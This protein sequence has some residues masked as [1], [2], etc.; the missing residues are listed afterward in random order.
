MSTKH[1]PH[2][3]PSLVLD[4]VPV[5]DPSDGLLSCRVC[6]NTLSA[7]EAGR[8]E[9]RVAEHREEAQSLSAR[10]EVT[11]ELLRR[12]KPEAARAKALQRE[13][14]AARARVEDLSACL[15]AAIAMNAEL[16][17]GFENQS[18]DF[19]MFI[20]DVRLHVGSVES[21][22]LEAL[23]AARQTTFPKRQ[24]PHPQHSPKL[25]DELRNE[26]ND[27]R[28]ECRRSTLH[29]SNEI[30][31]HDR[32]AQELRERS[33]S[34]QQE[35]QQELHQE[36]SH[37]H[38]IRRQSTI[39]GAT[40]RQ[41]EEE[42][43][44]LREQLSL[45]DH[46]LSE[47]K[48]EAT[49]FKNLSGTEIEQYRQE[50]ALCKQRHSEWREAQDVI[51]KSSLL[52]RQRREQRKQ[53]CTEQKKVLWEAIE[54]AYKGSRMRIAHLAAADKHVNRNKAHGKKTLQWKDKDVK[55]SKDSKGIRF[56]EW[57]SIRNPSKI[58]KF[59]LNEVTRIM[60]ARDIPPELLPE[61]RSW[62]C[63]KLWICGVP[64]IFWTHLDSVAQS[65][66]IALSHLCVNL[67]SLHSH[68]LAVSRTICK[69]GVDRKSR[70]K[71]LLSAI[72]AYSAVA[73][74]PAVRPTPEL[75]TGEHE[76]NPEMGFLSKHEA[77][78]RHEDAPHPEAASS[79]A[80]REP[81]PVHESLAS[82][83]QRQALAALSSSRAQEARTMD[84]E[85]SEDAFDDRDDDH[86]VEE[87]AE[88][89]QTQSST[90]LGTSSAD[91]RGHGTSS[92]DERGHAASTPTE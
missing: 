66:I 35:M 8:L 48:E 14:D 72:K 43:D 60:I 24:Q 52:L 67:D 25:I 58:Q 53:E 27:A 90:R 61:S 89:S 82:I 78:S 46:Q 62:N 18:Y 76:D 40:V 11:E 88:D 19:K 6:G 91:E 45:R 26:L 47:S 56:L 36:Q 64:S 74:K 77:S 55:L 5:A 39:L 51:D 83:A 33:L 80:H 92:P 17:R 42:A 38:S 49:H 73:P 68:D 34:M 4:A 70:A 59:N 84:P 50:F 65:F 16:K 15:R 2:S 54:L 29:L 20:D 30:V 13:R 85:A 9:Q 87:R 7:T 69:T 71:N 86:D 28:S 57:R 79:G 37:A 44:E 31:E 3:S 23:R 22:Y 81:E 21:E 1:S 41:V 63:F 75:R 32:L 10:L 12:A